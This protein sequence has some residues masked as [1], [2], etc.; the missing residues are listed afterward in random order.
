MGN[1]LPDF[2]DLNYGPYKIERDL[3]EE[4]FTRIDADGFEPT[5]ERMETE[6]NA[7]VRYALLDPDGDVV[8][9]LW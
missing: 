1:Y 2:T 3:L 6:I 8:S 9:Q 4:I 5:R 7:L